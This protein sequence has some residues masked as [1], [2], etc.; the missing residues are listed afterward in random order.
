[1]YSSFTYWLG[2]VV[3]LCF[4]VYGSVVVVV[5]GGMVYELFTNLTVNSGTDG[6]GSDWAPDGLATSKVRHDVAILIVRINAKA[7]L[8]LRIR[9]RLN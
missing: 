5:V 2:V 7:L 6:V 9:V 3:V 8:M 1:M 4:P